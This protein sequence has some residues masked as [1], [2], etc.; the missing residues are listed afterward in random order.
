[1]RCAH[2]AR[3]WGSASSWREL[4]V[5]LVTIGV[6]VFNGENYLDE[7][8]ASI[9]RQ[10]F[11]DF[12]VHISDNGSSDRTSDIARSW[13][14]KDPR[15]I[16]ER[17]DENIGASGNFNRLIAGCTTPYFRW[18][19]HDDVM[20]TDLLQACVYELQRNESLIGCTTQVQF[21]G[22][23]GG[24]LEA[25]LVGISLTQLSPSQRLGHFLLKHSRCD[26]IFGL[27]RTEVLRKTAQIPPY[28]GGDQVTLCELAI[29]GPRLELARPLLSLREHGARSMRAHV[30]SDELTKWFDPR[31]N[32]KIGS[33]LV[34]LLR[35]K[36]AM[37]NGQDLSF[38]QKICCKL[39]LYWWF[40][41]QSVV[42]PAKSWIKGALVRMGPEPGG[43][44]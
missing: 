1:M 25:K 43:A 10:T 30:S 20:Q 42:W 37:V 27:Y 3:K 38:F 4:G 41:R 11:T 19:A 7:A 31:S 22:P 8:L 16:Y 34:H 17:L 9:H 44:I 23:D 29:L 26:A 5:A 21:I 18:H 28:R 13:A 35:Q 15:F 24:P 36:L 40:L 12:V 39:L 6:P 33:I 32:L 14:A 2:G